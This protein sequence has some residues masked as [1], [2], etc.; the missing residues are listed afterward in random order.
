[1]YYVC[2]AHFC[3]PLLTERR[4]PLIVGIKNNKNL[5]HEITADYLPLILRLNET[6]KLFN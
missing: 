2:V 4:L 5:T 6:M 3:Y 1:M